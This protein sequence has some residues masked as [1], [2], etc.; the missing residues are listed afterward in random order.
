MWHELWILSIL[1]WSFL[2][3]PLIWS[4][5]PLYLTVCQVLSNSPC[6]WRIS[7][8]RPPLLQRN[9]FPRW[10]RAFILALLIKGSSNSHFLLTHHNAPALT[11][12]NR[13]ASLSSLFLQISNS[14]RR[15]MG[16]NSLTCSC[17][18]SREARRHVNVFSF[19]STPHV[20]I[21][22]CNSKLASLTLLTT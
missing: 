17:G 19:T 9:Q 7:R 14:T 2:L 15:Y 18:H 5:Y 20:F 6:L 12:P 13:P 10:T 16:E 21:I 11:A 22:I 3:P 8:A 1:N 4:S